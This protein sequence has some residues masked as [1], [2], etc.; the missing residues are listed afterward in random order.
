MLRSAESGYIEVLTPV[1]H[2]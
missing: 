1:W 2:T